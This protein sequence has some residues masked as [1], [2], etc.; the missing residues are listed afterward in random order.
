M[1]DI[2]PWVKEQIEKANIRQ[3][4]HKLADALINEI[5]RGNDDFVEGFFEQIAFK[6]HR[7]L[8]Q[9]FVRYLM[10]YFI[11][12]M[13]EQVGYD[14][15]NEGAVMLAREIKKLDSFLPRI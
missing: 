12:P 1:K 14:A 2:D 3:E 11:T 6:T 7:T 8:Q 15:R 10:E 5:N 4:G 13:A 9:D